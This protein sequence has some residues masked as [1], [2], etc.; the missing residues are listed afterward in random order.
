MTL[1]RPDA[2]RGRDYGGQAGILG[3]SKGDG[4]RIS[5]GNEKCAKGWRGLGVIRAPALGLGVDYEWL[6]G[7]DG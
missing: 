5:R 3:F 2:L 7:I 6:D 1:R 4:L